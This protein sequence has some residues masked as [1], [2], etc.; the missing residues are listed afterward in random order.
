M[1]RV[2]FYQ[3]KQVNDEKHQ[4]HSGNDLMKETTLLLMKFDL[5]EVGMMSTYCVGYV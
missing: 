1:V 3:L 4:K 5:R 2:G